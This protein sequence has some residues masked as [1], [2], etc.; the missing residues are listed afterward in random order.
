[1]CLIYSTPGT[2]LSL[3]ALEK[4]AQYSSDRQSRDK[5]FG[6]DKAWISERMMRKMDGVAKEACRGCEVPL[7]AF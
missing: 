2:G 4:M 7:R 1:M 5:I 3:M 6:K